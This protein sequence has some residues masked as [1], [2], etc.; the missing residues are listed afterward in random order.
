MTDTMG[1][2]PGRRGYYFVL[3]L[4]FTVN[5]Q[6]YNNYDSCSVFVTQVM[7]TAALQ[8]WV[9]NPRRPCCTSIIS[10]TPTR[11]VQGKGMLKKKS[12]P[13]A[14]DH[15]AVQQYEVDAS[16]IN[17]PSR[18]RTTPQESKKHDKKRVSYW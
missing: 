16:N 9:Q 18:V 12:P 13:R 10:V 4:V 2:P 8:Q 7:N 11:H 17:I 3:A 6:Y 14:L 15:Q 1:V 5:L